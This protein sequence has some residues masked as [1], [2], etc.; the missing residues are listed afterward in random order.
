M[1]FGGEENTFLLPFDVL[2]KLFVEE[3]WRQYKTLAYLFN[4]RREK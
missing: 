1:L 3:M 2:D 4:E